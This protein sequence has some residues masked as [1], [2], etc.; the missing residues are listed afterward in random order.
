[1]SDKPKDASAPAQVTRR[2]FVNGTLVGAGA[3][4]LGMASPGELRAAE[5][6][7]GPVHIPGQTIGSYLT[8]LG[9]DWT[10]PGGIGDYAACNGDT[11]NVVN[12]CHGGIRDDE[13]E[14]RLRSAPDTGERPDL[15]I[16]GCGIAGLSAAWAYRKERPSAS[17]LMLD[18]KPIFGGEA[19][20]NEFEVDGYHLTAPQ[21]STGIVV[22]FRNAKQADMWSPFSKELGFPDEFVFQKPQ[23]L[24]RNIEVPQDVFSPMDIGWW[25]ADMG[26]YYDGKGW[27]INPWRNG[28]KDAPIPESAKLTL[29]LTH[30][31]R[32]P[33][34]RTDWKQ[35]LDSMT[36][37]EFLRNVVG[38][39]TQDLPHVTRYL[40]PVAAS[41]GCGL[42][43][44]VISAYSAYN[45][46][47]P[48]VIGYYRY[49]N[50][51]VDPADEVYLAT[52]PGGNSGTARCFLKK[53]MPAALKGEY[54]LSDI[55]NSPV[56]WEQLDKP[57]EPVRMR[58]SSTVL[59]IVH[60]GS[61]ESAKGVVVTYIREGRLYKARAKAAVVCSQQHVNKHICRDL[62]SEQRDAMGAFNHAPMLVINVAVRNWRFLER[63]GIAAARWFDSD[64]L[65][66]W[67]SLRRNLDIPGQ[68]TQPLDPGKPFVFTMYNPFPLPGVPYP[69]QCVAARMEMFSM[70][71]A[72]IEAAVKARFTKMFGDYG[73]D[74]ERDIAG[75]IT[76][77]QGHAYFVGPPG[78]FFGKN[79]KPA[80][81]D[82]I[83]RGYGRLFFGHS[84]LSGAQMWENAAAEGARAARQSL[85]RT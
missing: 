51:G 77:R 7:T 78:F 24:S 18:N 80:P 83:S 52:F 76:N 62:G 42:G 48:G 69:K 44:D 67:I 57:N 5:K 56:Q 33:P 71:Y 30:S 17:V 53:I 25:R 47:Q 2:D 22:P 74:A 60:E 50:G 79:G 37:L 63:L 12:V 55:L 40:N 20:Q 6:Q 38:I 23:G 32:T 31:Y 28:F 46:L 41:M 58:L 61:P 35:W 85:E 14:S 19:K 15:I 4:L 3:A 70:R 84:E 43:A 10:G 66:W 72:Q 9:P 34:R 13:F 26:Y 81:K 59:S 39:S 75:I 54:R 16:V 82:V 45:F 29:L 49:E 8:G 36:Y 64:G 27:V 11:A 73:F 1:M 68:V 21:G 65:G